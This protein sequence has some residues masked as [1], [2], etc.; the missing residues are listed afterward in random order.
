MKAGRADQL[1]LLILYAHTAAVV[2]HQTEVTVTR[3]QPNEY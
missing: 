1:G 3:H 2:F